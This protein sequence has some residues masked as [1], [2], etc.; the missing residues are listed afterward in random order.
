ME[1]RDSWVTIEETTLSGGRIG[2]QLL[3]VTHVTVK[4]IVCQ[5][6]F[7]GAP[8]A[9]AVA[10]GAIVDGYQ[11]LPGLSSITMGQE[12]SGFNENSAVFRE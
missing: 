2:R 5:Q 7:A 12:G 8:R 1:V 6:A 9:R 11:P 4:L 3:W 10:T